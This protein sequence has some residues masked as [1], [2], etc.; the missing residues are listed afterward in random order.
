MWHINLKI[1]LLLSL[2]L[3]SNARVRIPSL[4]RAELKKI[5]TRSGSLV[6]HE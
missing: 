6:I 1:L 3:R 5:I 2:R 4:P